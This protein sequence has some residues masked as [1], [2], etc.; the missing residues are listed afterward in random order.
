GHW[1]GVH[2]HASG[3]ATVRYLS[4]PSRETISAI[5]V[6]APGAEPKLFKGPGADAALAAAKE[7]DW[8]TM[9][10][11]DCHNRKGHRFDLPAAAVDQAL[12]SGRI[13]PSL[14][15]IKREGVKALEATYASHAEAAAKLPEGLAAFYGK[16]YPEVAKEKAKE[17][18]AAGNALAQIYAGNVFPDMKVGWG[19]YP[20]RATHERGCYRCHDNEHVTAG[21]EKVSK[22]C[23]TCHTVIADQEKEPEVMEVLYPD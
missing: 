3:G 13:D 8:R 9:D 1:R 18:S 6:E 21:G 16:Q 14:P 5:R 2:W 19:T 22:R 20:D 12:A 10:C 7:G 11:M 15:F 4:D 23:G 17:V